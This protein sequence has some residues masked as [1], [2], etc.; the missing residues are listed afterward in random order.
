[1]LALGAL[2]VCAQPQASP[3]SFPVYHVNP[4]HE[5][6]FPLDMDTADLAGDAFFDLRSKVLPIECANGTGHH[7]SG[8]C[9]NQEVVDHDLVITKLTLTL[10]A[11]HFGEYGRC[12]ICGPAGVDPAPAEKER[13][14]EMG[15]Q[16]P[17][18]CSVQTARPAA[19]ERRRL[20]TGMFR[21]EYWMFRYM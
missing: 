16:H 6:V 14:C 21:D 19:V 4:L 15:E 17:G 3:A 1:M 20:A 8:D 9:S 18:A 11:N 5:G 13:V 2:V 12:N 10:R 7:Y